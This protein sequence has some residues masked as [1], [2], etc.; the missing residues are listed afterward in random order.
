MLHKGLVRA[1]KTGVTLLQQSPKER[2]L[3]WH[4]LQYLCETFETRGADGIGQAAWFAV[5]ANKNRWRIANSRLILELELSRA[6]LVAT[7]H[8]IVDH[9]LVLVVA[10]F[11]KE[12]S[13]CHFCFGAVLVALVSIIFGL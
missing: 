8:C 6:L 5:V 2:L 13:G 7:F 10:S 9:S 4:L 1:Q 11:I 3:P 12:I